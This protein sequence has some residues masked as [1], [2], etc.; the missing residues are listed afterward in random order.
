MRDVCRCKERIQL[1]LHI[2]RWCRH[3]FVGYSVKARGIATDLF[4]TDENYVLP[5]QDLKNERELTEAFC[6]M[7]DNEDKIRNHLNRFIPNYVNDGKTRK[8]YSGERMNNKEN[9]SIL[10]KEN[11]VECHYLL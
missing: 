8:K 4:G 3:L 5:V 7:I 10:A 1:L 9:I 2:Q 11:A 6:W